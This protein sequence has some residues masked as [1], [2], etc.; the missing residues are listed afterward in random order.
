[1]LY[2]YPKDILPIFDDAAKLA[3]ASRSPFCTTSI[4]FCLVSPV[5]L[6]IGF[7]SRARCWKF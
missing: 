7:I 2:N 6:T 1:M 3:Q 4:P 5:F